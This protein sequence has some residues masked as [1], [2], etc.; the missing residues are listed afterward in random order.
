MS[1]SKI[2]ITGTGRCGTTFLIHL[3]TYLGYKTGWSREEC[4]A[5]LHKIK[6]LR[7]GIEHGV[8]GERAEKAKVIKNPY[9]LFQR[10]EVFKKYNIEKIVL[11]IRDL[12]AAS[13]SREHQSES[14]DSLHGGFTH[15]VDNIQDQSTINARGVYNFIEFVTKKEIELIIISFPRIINDPEYLYRKL[16]NGIPY[17]KFLIEF[18]SLA[19]PEFVRF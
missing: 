19:N 4:D 5:E 2:L 17:E 7:G 15:G 16:F 18:N 10:E 13:K 14:L 12:D 1:D 3:Y 8:G 11:P 9:F 6:G